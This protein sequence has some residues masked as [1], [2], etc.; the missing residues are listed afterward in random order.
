ML[1][2][3]AFRAPKTVATML[4]EAG[5]NHKAVEKNGRRLSKETP[6]EMATAM[7]RE[8]TAEYLKSLDVT[9]NAVTFASRIK[10]QKSGA[11]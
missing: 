7:G 8:D 1:H 11:S 3:A 6:M 10:M 9:L 4:T 2:V 5:A